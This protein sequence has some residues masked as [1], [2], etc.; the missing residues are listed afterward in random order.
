MQDCATL[1]GE[2]LLWK[3]KLGI[4]IKLTRLWKDELGRLHLVLAQAI[5]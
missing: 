3:T 1:V 2:G 5:S 4:R